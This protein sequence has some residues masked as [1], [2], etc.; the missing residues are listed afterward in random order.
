MLRRQALRRWRKPLVVL[1]PKSLLRH[2]QSV[3]TLDELSSGRFHR[4]VADS[5]RPHVILCTGKIYF[6]LAA[7]RAELKRDDV[8]IVRL[9]QLYPFPQEARKYHAAKW[10]QEEP[11]N[12]GAW[13]FIRLKLGDGVTCVARP[14]SGSPA[15]GSSVRHKREQEELITRAVTEWP[16]N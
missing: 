14:E 4:V 7:K 6:E 8:A 16:S 1:T 3:S 5:E 11:V 13:A 2:P 10:V 9:E 12:M 15:A